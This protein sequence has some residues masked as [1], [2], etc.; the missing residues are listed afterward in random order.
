VEPSGEI[1][2]HAPA[3]FHSGPPFGLSFLDVSDGLGI[4]NHPAEDEQVQGFFQ[5]SIAAAVES[6]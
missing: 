1:A 4:E 2:F 6:V 5:G 3:D